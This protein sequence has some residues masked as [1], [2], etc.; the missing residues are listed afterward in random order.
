MRFD[1]H[2]PYN[3]KLRESQV[4]GTA[5]TISSLSSGDYFTIT[6]SNISLA[7]TSLTSIASDNSTIVGMSK[8]HLDGVYVAILFS[9]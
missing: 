1:L 3:S 9:M 6:N 7:T 2:I 4:V 8:E 5:V